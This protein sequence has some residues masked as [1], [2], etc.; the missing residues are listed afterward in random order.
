MIKN[1]RQLKYAKKRLCQLKLDLAVVRK[2]YSLDKN[3]VVLL[4]QGYIEHIAQLK[5]EIKEYKRMKKTP[6]P[7]VLHA[8]DSIE[9]SHQLVRLRIA[10]GLTQKELAARIG[11]KQADIS[12]LEREDYGGYTISQL[13]KIATNLDAGIE[14]NLILRKSTST[15]S[16]R[17]K[18]LGPS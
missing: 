7:Q 8:R 9:I 10:R 4:S 3:K 18:R 17:Y 5:A 1:S 13:K 2:K 15:S 6:L 14:L 11:C 16:Q 12:R